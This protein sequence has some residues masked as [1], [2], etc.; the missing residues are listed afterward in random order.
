MTFDIR[1]PNI[2]GVSEREQL[3]QI[4]SYLYR[5]VEQLN[6][7]LTTLSKEESYKAPVRTAGDS[8]AKAQSDAE[9]KATFDQLKALIIKSADIVEAYYEQINL[10]LSGIYVAESDFGTYIDKTGHEIKVTPSNITNL[11]TR[12]EAIESYAENTEAY[13][14]TGLLDN[15]NNIYG[16]EVGREVSYDGEQTF[17]A[18]ARFTPDALEFY[19]GSGDKLAWISGNKL[20]IKVAEITEM[21]ILGGYQAN[22][23]DGI[24]F[25]W[26][27]G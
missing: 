17:S 21:L 13:I 14:R 6:V 2:T 22:L 5:F 1:L 15:E 3:S 25:Q 20:Y 26:I 10:K 12:T 8:S 24:V 23:S 7:A 19:N 9:A 27:G 18:F 16:V 4:K 11:F